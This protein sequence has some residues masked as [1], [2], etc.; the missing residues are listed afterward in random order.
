MAAKG[1]IRS[2]LFLLLFWAVLYLDESTLFAADLVVRVKIKERS[3]EKSF[4]SRYESGK[5]SPSSET[6]LDRVVVFIRY[7]NGWVPSVEPEGPLILDQKGKTFVPT[8]LPILVGSTVQ[9]PN[10]DPFFH[11][12]FSLSLGNSFDLGHYP[13]GK[14]K[15][16]TFK[17][18]GVVSVY[19]NIHPSMK[20][21]ILVLQ[22]PYFAKVGKE[23]RFTLKDLPAGDYELVVWHPVKETT[24]PISIGVSDQSVEIIVG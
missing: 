6:D 16:V 9:F 14:S 5:V 7:V 12:V 23:G 20:G 22:N 2:G 1:I 4:P 11:N 15:S 10:S 19:C 17:K 21:Y 13:R 24:R 18:V 3:Q 8:V